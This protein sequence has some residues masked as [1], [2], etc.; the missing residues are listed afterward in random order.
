MV[1]ASAIYRV[2]R[3]LP[4][5]TMATLFALTFCGLCT[6]TRGATATAEEPGAAWPFEAK[7]QRDYFGFPRGGV[8]R[9]GSPSETRLQRGAPRSSASRPLAMVPALP[10]AARPPAPPT[11]LC[12]ATSPTP[13]SPG[14][15]P[16]A[17]ALASWPPTP[18]STVAGRAG[19]RRTGTV[20]L[21]VASHEA[22]RCRGRRGAP[23]RSD[24]PT[25]RAQRRSL[26]SSRWA[27]APAPL[28]GAQSRQPPPGRR[29]G[30]RGNQSGPPVGAET[31]EAVGGTG[32]LP[33]GR[34]DTAAR[35]GARVRSDGPT[36]GEPRPT[37]P[38]EA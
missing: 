33:G 12:G 31:P 4:N 28:P 38:P 15:L 37:H 21:T 23:P 5:E 26:A 7:P 3:S 34:A 22:G 25:A 11:S 16:G 29:Q 18:A 10:A 9:G 19:A 32:H 8:A 20:A 27:S 30:L 14:A 6:S 35:T 13:P 17:Q 24:G 36:A 1:G 2:V